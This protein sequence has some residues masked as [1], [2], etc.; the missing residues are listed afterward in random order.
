MPTPHNAEEERRPTTRTGLARPAEHATVVEIRELALEVL[1]ARGVESAPRL[2]AEIT[3]KIRERFAG[4]NLYVPLSR[5][6]LLSKDA[7]IW[8]DFDGRNHRELARVHGIS[9]KNVYE[10]LA[11][12]RQRRAGPDA[13]QIDMRRRPRPPENW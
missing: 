12:E 13:P 8:A 2:A 4:S 7:E 11:R 5:P 10:C 9:V 1:A 3:E 6:P